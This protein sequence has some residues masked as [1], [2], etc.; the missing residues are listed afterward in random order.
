[1]AGHVFFLAEVRA[2]LCVA[3]GL[4]H[5]D[6]GTREHGCNQLKEIK[7]IGRIKGKDRNVW[8]WIV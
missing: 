7:I 8:E 6:L 1:M 2:I 5:L 3:D 4:L